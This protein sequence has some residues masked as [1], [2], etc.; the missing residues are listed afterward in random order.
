MRANVDLVFLP[1]C[2][3][4]LLFSH[5]FI[6]EAGT[7]MSKHNHAICCSIFNYSIKKISL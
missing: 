7:T 4:T 5:E 1:D 6:V 2:M 3:K